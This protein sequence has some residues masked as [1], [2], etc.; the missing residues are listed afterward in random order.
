MLAVFCVMWQR[1]FSSTWIKCLIRSRLCPFVVP[2]KL[3]RCCIWPYWNNLNGSDEAFK[4]LNQQPPANLLVQLCYAPPPSPKVVYLVHS[5]KES[6]GAFHSIKIFFQLAIFVALCM[7]LSHHR[8]SVFNCYCG[9]SFFQPN[10]WPRALPETTPKAG[11]FS[12]KIQTKSKPV[13]RSMNRLR[14]RCCEERPGSNKSTKKIMVSLSWRH[15]VMEPI[16]VSNELFFTLGCASEA[17]S[18]C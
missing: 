1:L 14:F 2:W 11:P 13:P 16:Y 5:W 18:A 6:R 9:L 17:P 8:Q 4:L 3:N 10:S 7:I 12:I 15:I